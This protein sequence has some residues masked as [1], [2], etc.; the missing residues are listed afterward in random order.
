[1]LHC[2]TS[3]T[4]RVSGQL[5]TTPEHQSAEGEQYRASS[6]NSLQILP[7]APSPSTR[8]PPGDRHCLAQT[9]AVTSAP[10]QAVP[11]GSPPTPGSQRLGGGSMCVQRG[12]HLWMRPGGGICGFVLCLEHQLDGIFVIS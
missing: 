6:G 10:P 11:S 12:R 8:L 4:K 7:W 3:I 2:F 5:S 9:T 1:M